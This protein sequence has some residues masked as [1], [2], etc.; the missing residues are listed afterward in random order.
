MARGESCPA[1]FDF[2]MVANSER[3]ENA[4]AET[5]SVESAIPFFA[6]GPAV[7]PF[8]PS[9]RFRKPAAAPGVKEKP[10]ADGEKPT[11]SAHRADRVVT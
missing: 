2:W 7:I 6:P 5:I 1:G 11:C 9:R 3:G 10:D 4:S 8:I